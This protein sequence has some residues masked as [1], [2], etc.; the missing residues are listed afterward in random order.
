[1]FD[2]YYK[3]L[4]IRPDEQPANHYRL[5]GIALFED[6]PE[7]IAS[8]ADQRMAH[9]KSF[10]TGTHSTISQRVL[11]ELA[12]ARLCL[13]NPKAKA[14][15][16]RQLRSQQEEFSVDLRAIVAAGS[17]EKKQEKKRPWLVP[18]AIAGGGAL[19]LLVLSLVVTGRQAEEPKKSR[20]PSSAPE[21]R[22][23]FPDLAQ[24]APNE[25]SPLTGSG[26]IPSS[27]TE[28]KPP[29]AKSSTVVPVSAQPSTTP[30]EKP[31]QPEMVTAQ[32]RSAQAQWI[33]VLKLVDV[34][35]HSKVGKWTATNGGVECGPQNS[36]S[37]L[38]FPVE[39]N[40]SYDIELRCKLGL[41]LDTKSPDPRKAF[42]LV[43]PVGHRGCAVV[44]RASPHP[45]GLELID[46]RPVGLNGTETRIAVEPASE[47]RLAVQ[48]RVT[49]KTGSV[50]AHLDD[51]KVVDWH[52]DTNLLNILGEWSVY[53]LGLMSL[54]AALNVHE[55]RLRPLDDQNIAPRSAPTPKS[56]A[57]ETPPAT[58]TVSPQLS[59]ATPATP[60]KTVRRKV[61]IFTGQSAIVTPIPRTLPS[62]LEAWVFVPTPNKDADMYLFGSDGVTQGT[63]GLA[64]HFLAEGWTLIGR[65]HHAGDQQHLWTAKKLPLLKW[66]HVAVDFDQS[67]CRLFVDGKLTHSDKGAER[68]GSGQFVV[69]YLGV[70]PYKIPKAFLV[71]KVRTIR[72]TAGIR[73]NGD[74]QPDFEFH[75]A[76]RE[77]TF[78]TLAIYDASKIK[79]AVLTDVSGN[80]NHAQAANVKIEDDDV[81]VLEGTL[82]ADLPTG[83]PNEARPSGVV[84][85]VRFTSSAALNAFV[86]K[87]T[88]SGQWAVRDG[89]LIVSTTKPVGEP[90]TIYKTYF[91]SMSSVT[92]LAGLVPPQKCNL[93]LSV[94]PVNMILNWEGETKNFNVFRYGPKWTKETR[95]SP[96][97]LTPGR[98]HEVHLKQD[99]EKVSVLI[100]G[101]Q[102]YVAEGRL[103]GTVTVYPMG[104]T[105]MVKEIL[106]EGEVDSEKVV[107][108]PSTDNI[109]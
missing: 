88:D 61:F 25:P 99:G 73:Y 83:K 108:E 87:N 75:K 3:W 34:A 6:D 104:S 105:V 27:P 39:L 71:G 90:L 80:G 50:I 12:A 81:P 98:I 49:G 29:V 15:Y 5:L 67:Q 79:G 2:P 14:E 26:F 70:C 45:S 57:S 28:E 36:L 47:H 60:A 78:K 74:F 58:A 52:G 10:Q 82:S 55:F 42:R 16:D 46:G 103:A 38:L 1:M 41:E 85:R 69:G 21:Q 44:L 65:T 48:V 31:P 56:P 7:V 9:V 32:A 92:V 23:S 11:N 72:I 68:I 24:F 89:H 19:C 35:K 18:A 101:V 106:V 107:T 95:S 43:L 84:R 33:D 77:K 4:G 13:L 37:L 86:L 54:N 94:G 53:P 22:T 64:L 91:K 97:A 76:V 8:A 62:T 51:Q 96:H 109:Y 20:R 66:T 93:R 63:G 100:D 30:K 17:R 59:D 40:G 102:H